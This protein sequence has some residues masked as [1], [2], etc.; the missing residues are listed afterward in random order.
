MKLKIK[1]FCITIAFTIIDYLFFL[2]EKNSRT[3]YKTGHNHFN[4]I[5]GCEAS[6][7]PLTE[8]YEITTINFFF[9]F[10]NFIAIAF[11]FRKNN[12]GLMIFFKTI[13]FSYTIGFLFF[14]LHYFLSDQYCNTNHIEMYNPFEMFGV[15]FIVFIESLNFYSFKYLVIYFIHVLVCILFI[16]DKTGIFFKKLKIKLKK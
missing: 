4:Y 5:A 6:Y 2:L 7:N 15:Y 10:L 12:F 3:V 9:L 16:R 13:L 11:I 14:Y 8:V 1:I